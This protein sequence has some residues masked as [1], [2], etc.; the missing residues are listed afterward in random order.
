MDMSC[1]RRHLLLSAGLM[2]PAARLLRAQDP[3]QEDEAPI[4]T[5]GIKVVNVFV[6]VRRKTGEI[7][8]DLTKDDF[9]VTEDGRRQTIR[10][11]SRETDLPLTIGLAVDTSMSQKKVLE[12]E[13]SASYRFVDEVL[14]EDQDKVFV[15]QFDLGAFI[16]QPLTSSRKDLEA[17]L[18]MVDTPTRPELALQNGAGTVLYDAVAK[19]SRDIMSHQGNRKALFLL[20]D[21]VDTGSEATILDAID[22]AQRA[23]TLIYSILF[24]DEGYY[25]GFVGG[26]EGKNALK[27]MSQETGGAF[28]EVTKKEGIDQIY[29]RIQDEL[30][31]QYSLGFVSD[32]PVR[33]SEFRK[34][35]V[36]LK[37]KGLILE[38][39]DRYWAKR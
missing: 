2:L 36:T 5:T 12:S 32:R 16:R 21:G 25:G 19:A 1:T 26:S 35:Q 22:A 18:P 27:R 33:V 31:S 39:R 37:S 29:A 11:F 28:Y 13:R 10:Y 23:D 20:T 14:R 38:T 9:V 7:V 24:S 30:R 4:F 8:R 6:S 34:L 3:A 15:M 17:T